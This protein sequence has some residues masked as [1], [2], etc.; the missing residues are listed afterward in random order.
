MSRDERGVRSQCN[1]GWRHYQATSQNAL[2][3][4]PEIATLL[5]PESMSRNIHAE[6]AR[7]GG[8]Q[9]WHDTGGVRYH[10]PDIA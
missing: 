1:C 5:K 7:F 4:R 6:I 2:D 3:A 8:G 10:R 9:H